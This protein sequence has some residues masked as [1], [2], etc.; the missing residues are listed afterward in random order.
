[1]NDICFLH[2]WLQQLGYVVSYS[3]S[4]GTPERQ[5]KYYEHVNIY[6]HV[7]NTHDDVLITHDDVLC[8]HEDVPNNDV[9]LYDHVLNT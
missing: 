4:Y 9:I 5:T 7:L 2:K 8:T 3:T 1:M 6:Y